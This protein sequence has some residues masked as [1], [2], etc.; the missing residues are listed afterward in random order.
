MNQ[1]MIDFTMPETLT[2]R[3][4]GRIPAQRA[5]I[6]TYFAD[7]KLLSYAVSLESSKVWAVFNA[8]SESEVIAFV[9]ALPLTRFMNYEII[10]L[11]FYNTL[12][13]RI[14]NFSI[15]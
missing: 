7:G 9:E 1:Y 15:N 3:F 4:T 14:P 6:N 8:D 13:A 10:N 2:D 5:M 12:A 11:T